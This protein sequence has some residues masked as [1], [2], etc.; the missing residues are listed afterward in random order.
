M[1]FFLIQ[2]APVLHSDRDVVLV[3]FGLVCLR[4]YFYFAKKY[5][6][7]TFVKFQPFRIEGNLLFFNKRP[8]LFLLV[9]VAIASMLWALFDYG[10]VINNQSLGG[11]QKSQHSEPA[12]EK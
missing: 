6:A 2:P 10:N 11:T 4:I 3:I 7:S 9:L 1:K 12:S 8:W 5:N